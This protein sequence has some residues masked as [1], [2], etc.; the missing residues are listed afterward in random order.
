MLEVKPPLS[1][2]KDPGSCKDVSVPEVA[3]PLCLNFMCFI[4]RRINLVELSD[5]Q[6][7]CALLE[8][9]NRRS[10][11]R[12]AR[13]EEMMSNNVMGER[14]KI[15]TASSSKRANSSLSSAAPKVWVPAWT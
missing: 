2:A 1:G 4:C 15:I 5:A 12:K 6:K 9:P 13:L 3:V 7:R 14:D 8:G 11:L 10:R